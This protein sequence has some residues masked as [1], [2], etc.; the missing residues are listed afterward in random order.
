MPRRLRPTHIVDVERDTEGAGET[1][2]GEPQNTT[3]V[4]AADVPFAFSDR[5]TSFVREE[6]GERV[7][8]PAQGSFLMDVD[9]QEGDTIQVPGVAEFEV[10]GVDTVRDRRQRGRGLSINVEL[11]RV[12]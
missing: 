4:V 11:E 10:V 6:T 2:I 9:V 3:T 8:R 1:A 12:D 5:Q 7:Q